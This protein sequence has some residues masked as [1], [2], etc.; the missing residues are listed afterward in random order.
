MILAP[1][2]SEFVALFIHA[3]IHNNC[4]LHCIYLSIMCFAFGNFVPELLF[5]DFQEH[6]F[7]ESEV[8]F[9]EQQGKCP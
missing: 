2:F 9:G 3:F 4:L 1:K 8:F 6:V 7:E 5:E